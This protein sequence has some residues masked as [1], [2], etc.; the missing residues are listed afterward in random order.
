MAMM[1]NTTGMMLREIHLGHALDDAETSPVS[2]EPRMDHL[3]PITTNANTM[4]MEIG[5]HQRVT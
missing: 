1:T 3:P 4:M 5:A 2:L